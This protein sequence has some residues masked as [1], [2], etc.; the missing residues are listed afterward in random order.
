MAKKKAPAKPASAGRKNAGSKASPPGTSSAP[1][2]PAPPPGDDVVAVKAAATEELAASIPFNSNKPCEFGAENA[3]SPPTG[4]SVDASSPI[5]GS[6]TVSESNGSDKT[7]T[8]DALDGVDSLA[9]SLDRVRVDNTGRTLTTN[10]GVAVG[11]NQNSLK[12]GLRGP[13][14]LED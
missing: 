12:A 11:D 13:T 10:Q 9:G 3:V 6:S 7:G 14:L 1:A 2:H 8:G 4:Y 5:V